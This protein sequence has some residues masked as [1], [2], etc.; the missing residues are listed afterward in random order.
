MLQRTCSSIYSFDTILD[1]QLSAVNILSVFANFWMSVSFTYSH[2]AN[3][4]LRLWQ[5]HCMLL[6]QAG[7]CG[8]LVLL[9]FKVFSYLFNLFICCTVCFRISIL[10]WAWCQWVH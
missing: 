2:L 6:G 4:E 3:R 1:N 7:V 5:Q 9:L 10:C 8:E